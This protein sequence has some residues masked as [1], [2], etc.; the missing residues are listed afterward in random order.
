MSGS[1]Q[2]EEEMFQLSHVFSDMDSAFLLA[3]ICPAIMFQLSHVFSD[4]DRAAI[5]RSSQLSKKSRFA[6]GS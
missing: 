4:M 2:A 5:F 6:R 1:S 3:L